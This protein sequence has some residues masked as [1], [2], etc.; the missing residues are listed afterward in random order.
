MEIFDNVVVV[1]ADD[2]NH[3]IIDFNHINVFVCGH[4]LIEIFIELAYT[5]S[6]YISKFLK[7]FF[8][9]INRFFTI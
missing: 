2:L 1:V 4:I 5:H 6:Y 8:S 9:I 7:D 3:K